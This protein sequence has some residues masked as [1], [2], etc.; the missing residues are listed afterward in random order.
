MSDL[1]YKKESY[2]IIG[3]CLKVHS[4]LGPGFKEIVYNDALEL[5]F[6]KNGI[7][8]FREKNL[9]IGYNSHILKHGFDADFIVFDSIVL[10]IKGAV[11][12]HYEDFGQAL[13]YLKASKLKLALLVNF[14]EPSL[15]YKRII[16]T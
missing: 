6:Q 4:T 1:L 14:G 13:N 10:E 8:Y 9:R 15:R 3:C 16:S 5:E 7:P 2:Q 11:K 12:L